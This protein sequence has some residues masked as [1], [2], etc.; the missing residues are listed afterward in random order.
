MKPAGWLY[1]LKLKND[2]WKLDTYLYV[3]HVQD[4]IHIV[5]KDNAIL[6]T[7]IY[8]CNKYYFWRNASAVF[9]LS[10]PNTLLPGYL[11]KNTWFAS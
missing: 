5:I 11:L 4:M 9:A 8:H 7:K 10:V 3:N 6:D 2:S 1:Y